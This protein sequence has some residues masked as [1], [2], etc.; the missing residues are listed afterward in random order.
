MK[1]KLPLVCVVALASGCGGLLIINEPSD[2]GQ[3]CCDGG[4]PDAGPNQN[5]PPD[6]DRTALVILPD[7]TVVAD[8]ATAVTIRVMVRDAAGHLLRGA[9]VSMSCDGTGNAFFPA[10]ASGYT[11]TDGTFQVALT[12]TVAEPK[13]VTV[14]VGDFTLTAQLTFT[15]GRPDPSNSSLLLS[16]SPPSTV[17]A[18]G[19]QIAAATATLRDAN[20]NIVTG[21]GVSFTATGSSNTFDPVSGMV[22]T[23]AQGVAR[24]RMASTRAEA[25]TVVATVGSLFV[26]TRP[27]TYVAGGA[28]QAR[29]SLTANPTAL[30]AGGTTFLTVL[31]RDANG[32][33]VPSMPV[34]FSATGSDNNFSPGPS[35]QT[36]VDGRA[37]VD[38]TSSVAENKTI[39]A[40]AAGLNLTTSVRYGAGSP[41]NGNSSMQVESPVL[42][43]GTA[44]GL[45]TVTILDG[46]M[47]PVQ[48][49]NVALNATGSLN[50]FSP[51]A[52]GTTNVQGV[53]TARLSSTV[54]EN[55]A[56]SAVLSTFTLTNFMNFVPGPPTVASSQLSAS[57]SPVPADGVSTTTISA[58]FRDTNGNP[59]P[60]LFV[61]LSSTGSQNT[62]SATTGNTDAN[63]AFSATL[64]SPKSEVKTVTAAAGS[65][66]LQTS[67]AFTA[68][69]PNA[70]NSTVTVTPNAVI[71]DGWDRT[72]VTASV[73]DALGNPI[74]NV[75]VT[76]DATGTQNYW[77]PIIPIGLTGAAGVFSAR[78]E[79]YNAET[80]TVSATFASVTKTATVTFLPGHPYEGTSTFT[81]SPTQVRAN[82]ADYATLTL[83]V[84]DVNSNVVPNCPVSFYTYNVFDVYSPAPNGNTNAAGVFTARLSSTVAE[85]KEVQANADGWASFAAPVL[86]VPP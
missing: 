29:S 26:M 46:S 70:A 43:N 34:T 59:I 69:Q 73:K 81:I 65:I 54:S 82:G 56:V 20:R 6:K 66:S 27:V 30:V 25:K 67:I 64:R 61:T 72:T 14:A 19:V 38:L 52:S 11:A 77:D 58:I 10:S 68:G 40:Q 7:T 78:L 32:N 9:G 3:P 17:L 41:T 51:A 84:R 5:G 55:K 71:A 42:A 76:M 1:A 21:Y 44:S 2:G 24:T 4:L 8:G 36:D 23:D 31:A 49:A 28:V 74:P 86:F 62:F 79:S 47:N 13:T 80:K 18:D 83:T 60:N 33:P 57:P 75:E 37:R 35:A 63:G 15:A 22:L 16:P 53:F 48:G 45:I 50:T 12:S 85:Q 39:T